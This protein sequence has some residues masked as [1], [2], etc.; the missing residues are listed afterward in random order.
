MHIKGMILEF[1]EVPPGGGPARADYLRAHGMAALNEAQDLLKTAR[2]LVRDSS[3]RIVQISDSKPTAFRVIDSFDAIRFRKALTQQEAMV[4]GARAAD[5][6]RAA[7]RA[8]NFLE[9]FPG[10]VDESH[11]V[12]HEA[13]ALRSA[14][15]GCPVILDK[16]GVAWVDCPSRLAHSRVGQSVGMTTKYV[17]SV[18]DAAI[19]DCSH[20]PD[21]LYEVRASQSTTGEC[22]ICRKPSCDHEVGRVYQIAARPVAKD[23]ML[24]EVSLVRRPR[25]PQA[26][27]A[28]FGLDFAPETDA[29]RGAASGIFHCTICLKPCRGLIEMGPDPSW[30]LESL[31]WGFEDEK[32]NT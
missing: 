18:C 32:P 24:H 12:L 22:N 13:A 3:P 27:I 26:R 14:L 20:L 4:A 7:V 1:G 17:C 9:D 30:L 23:A 2:E 8:L 5:A 28:A 19:E 29:Y 21:Q 25:Y 15:I 11:L 6:E 31:L 10:L 16:D